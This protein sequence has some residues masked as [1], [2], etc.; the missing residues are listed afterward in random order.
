M[1]LWHT[2][3][4]YFVWGRGVS[5]GCM[6]SSPFGI[7]PHQYTRHSAGSLHCSCHYHCIGIVVMEKK[8][9]YICHTI[10][11]K[12]LL[13][14]VYIWLSLLGKYTFWIGFQQMVSSY[15]LSPPLTGQQLPIRDW[16]EWPVLPRGRKAKGQSSLATTVPAL[17]FMNRAVNYLDLVYR[18]DLVLS[19]HIDG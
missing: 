1:A 7:W 14:L 17:G 5:E 12:Y 8:F 3:Y 19:N 18:H 4:N 10:Y 9:T 16:A 2:L 6:E 15:G 11:L 13:L